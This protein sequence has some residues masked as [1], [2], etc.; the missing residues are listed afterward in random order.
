[1]ARGDTMGPRSGAGAQRSYPTSE[2]SGSLKETPR[3]R[4]QGQTGEAT[5]R[6]KPGVATLRSHPELKARGSSWK[7]LP[8]ERWLRR[9]R[10]AQ[11]SYPR[12]KVRNSGGKEIPLIQGKEQRLCLTGAAVKRY[13][14]VQSKRKPSK[15][16]SVARGHQRADTLKPYSENQSI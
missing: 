13:P 8:K 14:H 3:V 2:I 11:R 16:V 7:E 10:R 6:P 1:M 9:R 4:D 5:L 15:M 12:L